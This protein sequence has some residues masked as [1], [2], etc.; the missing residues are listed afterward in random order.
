M[1]S[2]AGTGTKEIFDTPGSYA[3]E[4]L[5]SRSTNGNGVATAYSCYTD[6]LL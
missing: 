4:G 2:V 1:V 6:F 3:A 5:L